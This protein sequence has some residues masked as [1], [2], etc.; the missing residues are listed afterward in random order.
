MSLVVHFLNVGQGD[1][2]IIEFPS[3][4][5]AMVDVHNLRCL[6]PSTREE[7]IA[8]YHESRE[9]VIARAL[10]RSAGELDQAYVRKREQ[11]LTDP[12]AYYDTHVGSTRN[13]FRMIVTHPDMDHMT[14][15]HR[16]HEQDPRKDILNFWHI[17]PYDFN[18]TDTTAEDWEESPYDARDWQTYRQLRG[19][20]DGPRS[21]TKRRDA[22]GQYWTDD[23]IEIWAPTKELVDQ[24]VQREEPNLASM[25]L[26]VSYAGRSIVLGGDATEETWS[27]I[28]MSTAMTGITVLKASHHGRESGFHGLSVQEMAPWLT[29]TSV[30]D[31]A[32]DATGRYRK[33]SAHTVSLRKSGDLR[34]EI[35]EDGTVYYPESLEAHWLSQAA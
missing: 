6:D 20:E 15:L 21:L 28:Y 13:I 33:H 16:I 23:G 12:L 22:K 5:V 35:R 32:H 19:G 24:A 8:E 10:G 7:L 2:T 30:G 4:R 26:K 18:L 11:E 9:F 31:K 17:G 27:Q 34:I 25:I 14:G 29:I 1:C 3:G